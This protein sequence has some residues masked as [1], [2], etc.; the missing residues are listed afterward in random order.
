MGAGNCT[1]W[2]SSASAEVVMME[3]VA[4]CVG[5]PTSTV[6]SCRA[7]MWGRWAQTPQ[8]TLEHPHRW[9]VTAVAASAHSS[10]IQVFSLAPQNTH[11]TLWLGTD[12]NFLPIY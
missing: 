6:P 5:A 12:L 9:Q 10:S 1:L 11:C 8:H 3:M 4:S 2:G 7:W